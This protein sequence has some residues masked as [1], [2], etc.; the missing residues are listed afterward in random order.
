MARG[1]CIAMGAFE[2]WGSWIVLEV[3]VELRARRVEGVLL[4]MGVFETLGISEA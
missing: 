4:A 1:V 3:W 2:T